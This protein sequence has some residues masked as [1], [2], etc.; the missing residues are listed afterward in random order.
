MF[1]EETCNASG[2]KFIS[3]LNEVELNGTVMKLPPNVMER[4]RGSGAGSVLLLKYY[5]FVA[6]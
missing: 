4:G 6:A 5:S 1:G 3:F 2:N